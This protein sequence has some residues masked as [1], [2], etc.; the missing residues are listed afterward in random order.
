LP[1]DPSMMWHLHQVNCVWH[2]VVGASLEWHALNIVKYPNVF[3]H[4]TIATQGPP[5]CSLKQCLQFEVYYLKLCFL[6]DIIIWGFSLKVGFETLCVFWFC[7]SINFDILNALVCIK[8]F[9]YS[10]TLTFSL[11]WEWLQV[12]DEFDLCGF[13]Y[14]PKTLP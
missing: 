3:Y 8:V 11:Q 13:Q 10:W 6:D 9:T 4:H 12:F 2:R 5:R 14:Y 1:L 7:N